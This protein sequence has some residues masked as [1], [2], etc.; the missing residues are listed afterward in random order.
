MAPSQQSS[1]PPPWSFTR[2]QTLKACPRKYYF[3]YCLAPLGAGYDADVIARRTYSLSRLTSL[4]QILGIAIHDCA[5]L[6]CRAIGRRRPC[7]SAEHLSQLVRN[8]LNAA[9]RA[10]RD[11]V[12]CGCST[13]SIPPLREFHYGGGVTRDTIERI[14][15]KAV[16][17]LSHL[18][19]LPLW[20]ALRTCTPD[21][22][23]VIDRP[24]RFMCRDLI[25][26]AAPDLVFRRPGGDWV[27]VDWKTGR[28]RVEKEQAQLAIYGLLL[29]TTRPEAAT[30]TLEGCI[31]HL[32]HGDST[33]HL[34]TARRLTEAADHL[35][36]GAAGIRDAEATVKRLGHIASEG[37]PLT[38]RR[39]QCSYC[40]FFELCEAELRG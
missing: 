25:A 36:I 27:V 6:I 11:A 35:V 17:C 18:L 26:L 16:R 12:Q 32:D 3:Q 15:S 40:N 28:E 9:Y 8:A 13:A 39:A 31:V 20:E 37:F 29:V 33:E 38:S 23:R 21:E 7:P 4:D 30:R 2:D 1:A 5:R 34:L 10:S 22:I 24:Q 19:E 14:R